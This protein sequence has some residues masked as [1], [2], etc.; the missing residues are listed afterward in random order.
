MDETLRKTYLDRILSAM[1]TYGD[2]P[3]PYLL[4]QTEKIRL[5]RCPGMPND[6]HALLMER[7]IRHSGDLFYIPAC[8]GCDKCV[9]LRIPVADFKPSKKQRHIMNK[10]RDVEIRLGVPVPT[11]EKFALYKRYLQFQHEDSSDEARD[12]ERFCDFLYVRH[13][14]SMEIMYCVG[15]QVAG[16]T[17]ADLIPGVGL[18]SVYHYFE[19]E[20]ATRS[21]GVFSVLAEIRLCATFSVPYYYLGF[22]IS[23]CKKM[24]YTAKYRPNELYRGGQWGRDQTS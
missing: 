12:Y 7:G 13:E 18:S 15:E 5:I 6:I 19:P 24:A 1:R 20:F 22:W 2:A 21:I 3:C 23:D 11:Q 9:P 17:I 14:S 10:N 8:E 4:G 16:I